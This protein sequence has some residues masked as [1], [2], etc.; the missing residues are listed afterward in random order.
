M[1]VFH[2]VHSAKESCSDNTEHVDSTLWLFVNNPANRFIVCTFSVP[3]YNC[4]NIE[5][6]S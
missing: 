6:K 1:K 5:P 2:F 3:I 4:V